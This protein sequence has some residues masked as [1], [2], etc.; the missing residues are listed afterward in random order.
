MSDDILVVKNLKE[1]FP[2]SKRKSPPVKAVDDVSFAVRRGETLSLVGESGS[3][4]T[5]IARSL[6]RVW[7]PTAG[8]AHFYSREGRDFNIMKLSKKE[9]KEFRRYAQ[10]IFQD[11][12]SS[13]SPRMTVYDIIGEPL[14]V[15]FGLRGE[16][17]SKRVIE[18]AELCGL[19]REYLRRYPHAFSGGQ[20]QRIGI[21]RALAMKPELV[22]CDEPV[23]AL[24]VSIQ[25]KILNLLKD[26]QSQLNLSYLFIAHDLS[27]VKHI[28]DRIVVLYLGR[29]MEIAD[30][31]DL[32]EKPLHP[33]T[34]ALISAIP[35]TNPDMEMKPILLEGEIPNSINP[36]SGCRFHPRCAYAK[37]ICSKEEPV[38]KAY[39]GQKEDR[40]CACHFAGEL[41]L[42]SLA[43]TEAEE[44]ALSRK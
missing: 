42:H 38:L 30:V 25:A 3:G 43:D 12:Y 1:Y 22:V 15:N 7:E 35:P 14:M 4:K 8:E 13:L 33:Y 11:P 10:M 41:K 36:P 21:A 2:G 32:F 24:D 16:E 29:I 26:L 5:T 19:N 34:E 23:S 9:L 39:R 6:L 28:S 37:D 27:V 40:F 18:I 44:A 17:L 20:R 31:D